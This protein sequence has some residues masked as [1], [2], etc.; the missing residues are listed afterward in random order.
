[1][2]YV[3]LLLPVSLT[4]GRR[5][6]GGRGGGGRGGGRS[7]GRGR[8][9]SRSSRSRSTSSTKRKG[10]LGSN[11]ATKAAIAAGVI[12]GAS[13]WR[14]RRTYYSNP[15]RVPTACYNDRYVTNTYGNVSYLGRFVCPGDGDEDDAEYCCGEEGQQTCC[16]YFDDAGRTAGVIIGIF[17]AFIVVGV[18]IFCC[19]KH[20][21]KGGKTP[22]QSIRSRFS[23]PSGPG[24]YPA[25]TTYQPYSPPMPATQPMMPQPMPAT[26]PMV[27]PPMYDTV[28]GPAPYDV[29]NQGVPSV[30]FVPPAAGFQPSPTDDP[31]APAGYQTQGTYPAYDKPGTDMSKPPLP[32]GDV[33]ATPYPVQPEAPPYPGA[34]PTGQ[35]TAPP[36]GVQP[37]PAVNPSPQPYPSAPVGYDSPGALPYPAQPPPQ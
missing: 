19:C 15:D 10:Y 32:P 37:Y 28:T 7:S 2:L 27:P 36:Y 17:V 18:C 13:S 9:T 20:R 22:A 11:T 12:Y 1:M 8:S 30:G 26:Q 34:Y 16:S 31:S 4:E 23:K 35:N 33:S 3:T 29:N 6:G 25:A 14:R 24:T 5:G 21:M